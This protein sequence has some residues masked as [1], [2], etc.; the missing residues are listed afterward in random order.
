MVRKNIDSTMRKTGDMAK[1]VYERYKGLSSIVLRQPKSISGT[2]LEL[3][4]P[5]PDIGWQAK[6]QTG[7]FTKRHKLCHAAVIREDPAINTHP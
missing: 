1:Y 4:L 2:L 7:R 3:V 6:E 5:N